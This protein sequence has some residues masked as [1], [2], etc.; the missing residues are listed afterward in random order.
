MI[1]EDSYDVNIKYNHKEYQH[2]KYIVEHD[3]NNPDLH[4]EIDFIAAYDEL[5]RVK[6]ELAKLYHMNDIEETRSVYK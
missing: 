1:N 4:Y 5:Q 2:A 6:L 3:L